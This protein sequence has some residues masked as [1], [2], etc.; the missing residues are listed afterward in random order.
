MVFSSLTFISLF[1]PITI[2][3]YYISPKFIKNYI[4]L[5][6]SLLF[7]SW[8]EPK[9]II[10]ILISITF[11]YLIAILISRNKSQNKKRLLLFLTI[12]FNISL[13]LYFKYLNFFINNLNTIFKSNIA[14]K[15]IILPIGIS[16]Y[17]FQTL[18]YVI[19]VYKEN[20]KVQKN[21][22]YLGMYITFF[23]Q[24]I[25]GP[26]VRYSD[27]EKQIV[28]RTHSIDNFFDGFRRF[29]IGLAKKVIIANNVS[30]ICDTIF[31]TYYYYNYGALILMLAVLC[32]TIQIYYDFSGYSDMAIG[33]GKMFG[34]TFMENFNYPYKAN[35]ITDFWRRWH[36]SLSTWFRDYVYI[37][38]GGNRC[39]K[40]RWLFNLSVVW[41]LTGIWHGAS[42]NFILWG[43]YYLILLVVEKT[44]NIDKLIKNKV[45][46]WIITFILINIGWLIFKVESMHDLLY[47]IKQILV[48]KPS[49]IKLFITNNYYIL[50][51]IVYL[52]IGII[53]M[54][55][56]IPRIK[57]YENKLLVRYIYDLV[58]II[59]FALSIV[60]LINNNYNP[61]IYFRF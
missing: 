26:I 31:N 38:L 48:F 36:I 28:K 24:L 15:N 61:F 52:I 47:I 39:S 19:D 21:I 44:F 42:W 45:L 55:P 4:L 56:I 11:N 1:L 50:N 7:Y 37:P 59:L 22:C 16:F 57:K 51:N 49:H 17:T 29:I 53:F 35:S 8:G 10:L 13:L 12:V 23:P 43:I 58:L 2:I 14:I 30:I 40:K 54:F 18:S 33:L 25:A 5:L 46:K 60:F 20:V 9:Y 27:I 6:A 41:L 32:F 34:F 3:L